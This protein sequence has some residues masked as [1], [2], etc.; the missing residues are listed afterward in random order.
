MTDKLV[1][2]P[3]ELQPVGIC[4]GCRHLRGA[5]CDAFPQG[6]PMDIL[7]GEIDHRL[8]VQGDR[9]IQFEPLPSNSPA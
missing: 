8:P 9:G 4:A 7:L 2:K 3:G 6:I 5:Y 1:W